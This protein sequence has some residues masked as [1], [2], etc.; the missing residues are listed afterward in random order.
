M[1]SARELAE[2]EQPSS[3]FF[4]KVRQ[5]QALIEDLKH[6]GRAV[7]KAPDLLEVVAEFY[8]DLFCRNGRRRTVFCRGLPSALPESKRRHLET[9]LT[10][11]EIEV[12]MR[13]LKRGSAPGLDSTLP[14]GM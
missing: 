4:Q 1:A 5:R 3:Y 7:S 6:K 8:K 12:V 9:W 11:E 10:L 13:S 14:F 2:G